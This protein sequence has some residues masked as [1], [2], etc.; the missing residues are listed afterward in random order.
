MKKRMLG[1]L[2]VICIVI[3]LLPVV[4]L[5]DTPTTAKILIMSTVEMAVTEGGSPVYLKNKEYDAYNK[6]DGSSTFKAWTQEKATQDNWNVKFEWPTGG[7]P[8]VT[9]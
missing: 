6:A 9:L 3:G 5:A 8:T 7:T 4:A 2:L 1:L